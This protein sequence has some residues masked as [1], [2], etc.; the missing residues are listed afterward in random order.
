MTR[1][2][3]HLEAVVFTLATALFGEER[4]QEIEASLTERAGHLTQLSKA[5]L[6]HGEEPSTAFDPERS[7][8]D[9]R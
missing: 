3:Q 7:G 1:P 5:G 8:G 2:D 6:V 4:V 9:I